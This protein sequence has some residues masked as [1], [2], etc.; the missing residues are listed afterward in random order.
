MIPNYDY[1]YQLPQ[2]QQEKSLHLGIENGTLSVALPAPP[3]LTDPVTTDPTGGEMIVD[4][5]KLVGSRDFS[6]TSAGH[7]LLFC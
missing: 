3:S 1:D 6:W 5:R 2:T 7:L 4:H